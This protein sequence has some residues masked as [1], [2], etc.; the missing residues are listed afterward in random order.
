MSVVTGYGEQ[1]V[2]KLIW[3]L[4]AQDVFSAV[5]EPLTGLKAVAHC[6]GGH[7]IPTQVGTG[8]TIGTLLILKE[9]TVE[10][11]L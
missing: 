8:E 1:Q 11:S 4:G 6:V 7:E 10:L 9:D 5:K 2:K 3:L